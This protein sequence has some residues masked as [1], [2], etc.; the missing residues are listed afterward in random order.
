M[1]QYRQFLTVAFAKQANFIIEMPTKYWKGGRI[2][3][4]QNQI[5]YEEPIL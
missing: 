4:L 1:R 5:A 2:V 3:I